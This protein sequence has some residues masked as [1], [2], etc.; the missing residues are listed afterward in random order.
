[1]KATIRFP[2]LYA[3]FEFMDPEKTKLISDRARF[4]QVP[5]DTVVQG[6]HGKNDTSLLITKTNGSGQM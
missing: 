2:S 3:A 1:M 4:E 5:V 6:R